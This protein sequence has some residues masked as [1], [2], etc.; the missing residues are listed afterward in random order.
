LKIPVS[1]VLRIYV[2]IVGAAFL[3]AGGWASSA[4]ARET[5]A[6][7]L[8]RTIQIGV[9]QDITAEQILRIADSNETDYTTEMLARSALVVLQKDDAKLISYDE[10]FDSLLNRLVDDG[11]P[12]QPLAGLPGFRGKETVFTMVYALVMSGN[13]ERAVEI[14]GKNSLTGGRY[15]QA[16]VLS[17]LRNIGTPRAIQ[18]IQQYAEKGQD[19]N[20]AETTLAD[21]DYPVL[22]EIHDRWNLVPPAQ[23][24]Q[25][26]LR[27]LVQGGCDQRGVLAA[28]WLGFFAP[29]PDP[30]KEVAEL[31]ALEGIAR[32]NTGSCEMMEHVI[33]LKALGLR[34]AET[35]D[36][37]KRLAERTP[38]VWERHQIVINAFGRWGAKFAPAALELFESDTAQYV[39]WELLDGNLDL[40]QE[41]EYRNYWDI[42]IPADI[43][44]VQE[45]DESRGP[46]KIEPKELETMLAWLD[47]GGRPRDPVVLNHM[48]YHL[49]EFTSG[50][51]TRRLLR[52]F[53]ALPQRNQNWWILQTV[54]DQ[55]ALPLLEYWSTLPAPSDQKGML[56]HTIGNLQRR[57]PGKAAAA[58]VC[59]EATEECLREQV[60]NRA[61]IAAASSAT[62]QG[63]IRTEEEARN[64]LEGGKSAADEFTVRYADELKRSASVRHSDGAEERWQY[65]F[66]CWRNTD[67]AT[68]AGATAATTH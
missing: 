61:A 1:R 18:L 22:S 28:Y 20:L 46:A 3:L 9:P 56:E 24:T 59:C 21:E 47:A 15:K 62:T 38:N 8:L 51:D 67:P 45:H 36:Y 30:N 25:D 40:R 6:Q 55:S 50:D 7:R 43:L 32:N 17:A 14:L 34:S 39:Q 42:W 48:I 44:V 60:R 33:A 57:T 53:N 23:R 54:R 26:T 4:S 52:V 31:Q 29:N 10:L 13:Q 64:W 35:V 2:V 65:L 19:R 12:F 27:T 68:S 37:W 63:P 49:A 41:R 16:V 5:I 11:S 66:D 58:A